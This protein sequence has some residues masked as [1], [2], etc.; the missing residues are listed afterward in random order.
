MPISVTRTIID[1]ILDGTLAKSKFVKHKY[2]D[3]LIPEKIDSIPNKILYPEEGWEDLQSY[4]Q[5]SKQLLKMF[6]ERLKTMTL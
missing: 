2:T 4:K 1:K 3:F 6:V 5:K